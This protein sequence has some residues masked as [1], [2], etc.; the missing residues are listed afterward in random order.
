MTVVLERGASVSAG[1][2]GRRRGVMVLH[3]AIRMVI[4]PSQESELNRFDETHRVLVEWQ[5]L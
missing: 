1:S 4:R 3:E 5:R 2:V